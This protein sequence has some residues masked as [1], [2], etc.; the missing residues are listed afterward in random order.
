MS[1]HAVIFL[2][3]ITPVL[4]MLL[5]LLGVETIPTNPLGWFLLLVGVIYSTGVII[6]Y[7][8]RKERFWEGALDRTINGE[9]SG[10]RSFWFITLGMSASFFLS[11]VEYL[12]ISAILPR[13]AWMSTLGVGLVTLGIVLFVWAR[14]TLRKNYSGHLSVK[15]GQT[16]VQ[17]GIYGYIRHPAYAG[18]LLMAMGISLGYSSLAG[19]ISILLL[20]LTS[21]VYRIKVEE[22]LLT[23]LFGEA[24]LLYM[25]K[26]KRLIP[27]IW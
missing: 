6:A 18:Y 14:R 2:L 5:A 21:V 23:R 17:S 11:P 15:T 22:Q 12:Y 26:T 24:Y 27:G 16:L 1:T 9:E 10:D 13:N 20:M 3:G 4:A 7:F 8:V 19:L 25:G